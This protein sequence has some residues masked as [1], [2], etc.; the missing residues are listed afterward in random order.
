VR[1]A[2]CTQ[3]DFEPAKDLVGMGPVTW[4]TGEQRPAQRIEILRD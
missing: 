1:S 2:C 4:I 3:G